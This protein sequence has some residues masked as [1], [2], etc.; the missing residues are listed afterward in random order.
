VLGTLAAPNAVSTGYPVAL[1]AS[2]TSALL[3]STASLALTSTGT[4]ALWLW[5][6]EAGTAD[7][8]PQLVLTFST[9]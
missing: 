4:D 8:R 7:Y 6:S 1:G 5:S 3:G 2:G 9:D